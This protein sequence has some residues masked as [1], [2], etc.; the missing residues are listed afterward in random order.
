[1]DFIS[2]SDESYITAERFRSICSFSFAASCHDFVTNNIGE[3]TRRFGIDEFKWEKIKGADYRNCAIQ[4]IDFIVKN[5]QNIDGRIDVLIWDTHDRRHSIQNRDDDANFERMF[6]HLHKTAMKRRPINMRWCI[7]PD[8][9]MGVDWETVQDCLT[10]IGQRREFVHSPLVGDFITD[11]HYEILGFSQV[12]SDRNPC[13]QIADF[14]AGIS[15]FSRKHYDGYEIWMR[16]QKKSTLPL[17]LE[18]D[19]SGRFSNRERYRFEVLSHF[20]KCC[21]QKRLGVSLK[22]KRYLSTPN[23][24]YPINFWHYIPQHEMDKAPVKNCSSFSKQQRHDF[25]ASTTGWE[26]GRRG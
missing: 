20:D 19:S 21:K 25:A 7:Y 8:E 26:R 24:C 2:Y 1:M 12:E 23:P 22:T 9:K 14:F 13:C 16:Q 11:H 17:F 18:E 6:F 5:Y 4:L 3:I 10:A 15:V